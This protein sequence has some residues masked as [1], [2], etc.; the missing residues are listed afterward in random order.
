MWKIL[1]LRSIRFLRKKKSDFAIFKILVLSKKQNVIENF[2][3][4]VLSAYTFVKDFKPFYFNFSD[5][6]L[7]SDSEIIFQIEIVKF[8]KQIYV[9]SL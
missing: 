6:V 7:Y 1:P 2:K 3:A 4:Y 5:K 8:W 9:L